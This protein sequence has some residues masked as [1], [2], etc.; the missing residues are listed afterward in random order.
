[1][2]SSVAD[3]SL[4]ATC[5]PPVEKLEGGKAPVATSRFFLCMLNRTLSE[6]SKITSASPALTEIDGITVN[7]CQ[8]EG[9]IY[10][11]R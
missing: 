11:V 3:D 1:M 5:C 6:D 9:K 4:S 8:S 7:H 2:S 10:V